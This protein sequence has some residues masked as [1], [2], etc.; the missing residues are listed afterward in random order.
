MSKRAKHPNTLDLNTTIA[1][2]AQ[3]MMFF[4]QDFFSKCDQIHRKLVTFTEEILN[5]KPHFLCSV[6]RFVTSLNTRSSDVIFKVI[7]TLI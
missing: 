3:K 6:S 4:T 1:N 2:T 5:R 7:L